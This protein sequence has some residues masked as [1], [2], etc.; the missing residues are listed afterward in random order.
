[1]DWF[2]RLPAPA[3]LGCG[4]GSVEVGDESSVAIGDGGDGTK[5]MD[6]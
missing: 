5:D 6:N 2:S 3:R 4:E 1:V